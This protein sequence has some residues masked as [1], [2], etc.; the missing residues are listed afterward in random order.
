[1][2]T[3]VRS[4]NLK[5]V[6]NASLLFLL[7]AAI[8]GSAA[9]NSA[10]ALAEQDRQQTLKSIRPG[11]PGVR[12][13]WN[14]YS[15]RFI[16]AP[17][18][19]F[20]K[21]DGAANYHFVVVNHGKELSFDAAK[22][23]DS[24]APIWNQIPEGYTEL[25][26]S[27]LDKNGKN[28]GT[29]GTRAFYRSPAYDGKV[30]EL[31]M[32]LLDSGRL[33]LKALFDAGHV[34][35]WLKT[36]KPD[37]SY[38]LYCYPA[39]VMG[40]LLR[41]MVAYSKVAEKEA[42]RKAALEIAKRV[43][44][45]LIKIS[46][47]AGTPDA[48]FPPTYV[49]DV[50]KPIDA[51]KNSFGTMMVAAACDSAL[52]YLDLFDI[53]HDKKYFDAAKR[54]AGT[55]AKTQDADGTWPLK[56]DVKTGKPVAPNRLVPTWVIFLFDRF[57]RQYGE[58]GFRKSREKA[59]QFIVANP[60]KTFQWDGQFEDVKP[61]PP[62]KNLAREQACDVAV[63]L[64]EQANGDAKQIATAKELISFA[65]DQFVFWT[66]VT[67]IEGMRKLGI[68]RRH[69]QTWF[70]PCVME[71]YSCYG[72]VARSS[73]I[74]INAYLV[75]HKITGEQIYFEKA[76]ALTATLVVGQ[77]YQMKEQGGLGEIPTWLYRK[78]PRNWLNNSYYA[79]A[80]VLQMAEASK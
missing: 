5:N 12:P 73:A 1:M 7:C 6:F 48:F 20:K 38:D 16:Y 74:L 49:L 75:A 66:P 79:A 68:N 19:D 55:Y 4:L 80:A 24:L 67:D 18:F 41:G 36:G 25:T 64:L 78:A 45:H 29:A 44:D 76:R 69:A 65:E 71:Q 77:K 62:Y 14:I 9:D 31:P 51:A 26:V 15:K 13:F 46:F 47:E 54:I 28:I 61:Q 33:G 72:P 27:A 30:A 2:N 58:T 22:P 52:G 39:K 40:G 17:S 8:S 11:E 21:V 32:P 57:D 56:N 60:L 63:I 3:T 35:N 43:A 53:T 34:Q 70:T 42:D 23:W 59:W 37:R 10:K 50:E